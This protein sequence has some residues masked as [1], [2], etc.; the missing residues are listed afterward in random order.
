MPCA[1][2]T[3]SNGGFGRIMVQQLLEMEYEVIAG[4]RN[5]QYGNALVERAEAL[6]KKECLHLFELDITDTQQIEKLADFVQSNMKTLDVLVNNAGYCQG[7]IVEAL[8]EEEW[9]H[10]FDVNFFGTVKLT[11][12]MLPIF[13][14][15]RFGSI[16]NVS[17]ISGYMGM[18]G[19]SAYASSKFALEGFSESLR[20]EMLPFHVYVSLIEPSSYKTDIWEK[21]LTDIKLASVDYKTMV[22]NLVGEARQ[23]VEGAGDPYEI[24]TLLRVILQ[25]K[26]PKLRYPLGKT[27]KYAYRWRHFLPK[28]WLENMIVKRLNR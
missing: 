25:A 12:A 24:A 23:S 11:T 15:Q 13:R 26:R 28:Q 8:S 3:G 18:P 7:G 21:A 6:G 17:S 16:I 10:Q 20:Y 2:V 1:V 22:E 9:R 4:V 27:A 19:M 5:L 14:K